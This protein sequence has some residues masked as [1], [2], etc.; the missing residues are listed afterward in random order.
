MKHSDI[1][2]KHAD[3]RKNGKTKKKF[4]EG[5]DKI[6]RKARASFKNYVRELEEGLL[7]DDLDAPDDEE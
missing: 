4:N 5:L 2:D 1:Y 3:S 7:E 6:A